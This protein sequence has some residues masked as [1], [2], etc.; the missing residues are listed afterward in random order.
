MPFSGIGTR[1]RSHQAAAVYTL[2]RADTGIGLLVF[3]SIYL[4]VSRAR[5]Q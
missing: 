5:L 2:D 3:T 1:D 4:L